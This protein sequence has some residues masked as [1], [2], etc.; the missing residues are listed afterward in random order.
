MTGKHMKTDL[1]T[2]T[3]AVPRVLGFPNHYSFIF[4]AGGS[5]HNEDQDQNASI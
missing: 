1:I 2:P 5:S 4:T 3:T